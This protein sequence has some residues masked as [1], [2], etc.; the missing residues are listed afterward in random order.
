M[1]KIITLV[2]CLGIVSFSFAQYRN[3]DRDNDYVYKSRVNH[4][5]YFGGREFQIQ[6]INREFDAK[7]F[8]IKHDWTLRP[9]Q[10]RVA[11]RALERERR[12][13]IRIAQRIRHHENF[14]RQPYYQ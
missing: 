11:I 1:K 6:K 14:Y 12:R 3:D 5:H 7:I 4:A 13:E 10:K 9:H 8:A 2:I